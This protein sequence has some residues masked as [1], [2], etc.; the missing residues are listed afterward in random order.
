M[1][2]IYLIGIFLIVLVA[3]KSQTNYYVSL[4][5]DD[6]NTGLSEAQAWRTITF[7]VSAMS[8]VSAG[9]RVNVKAGNYGAENI[10]VDKMGLAS[11]VIV[12]EGYQTTPG[13]SPNL[14]YVFG[15][16]LDASVMPLL[17]GGNRATAGE[18]ITLYSQKYIIFK[19]FQITNYQV[20]VDG[21]NGA[22]NKLENIIAISLGDYDS[23]YDGKGFSFSP[24]GSGEGGDHNTI[25]D[26]VVANAC[27]E[28]ISITGDGNVLDNCKIYCDEDN[29]IHASMDYYIILAGDSNHVKNCYIERVG[30]LEHGGAGIGI[31]E[32]G[33]H[34]LIEN[35]VA[36]DLENGGFYVRWAAVK[37]NEFRNCKAIGTLADV[38][39][40][41][42]R[43]GA[44]F[45]EFNS[46]VVENCSSAIRFSVSGEDQ[47]YCGRNNTFNNCIIKNATSDIEFYS[48]AIPGPADNNLF[49]N[50]VFDKATYLFESSRE[51]HDNQMINCIV[52][53]V[54]NLVLGS[55]T[56]NF[57]Y[58]YSDFNN[59]G[60]AMPAGTGNIASNPQFVD[61]ANGDFHLQ[62]GSPCIDAGTANNA[63]S[64]DY[65]GTSRPQ[66]AG[67]EIGAYEFQIPLA[68]EY[69]SSLQASVKGNQVLLKWVVASEVNN[70]YFQIERSPDASSWTILG[71]VEGNGSENIAR[72]YMVYDSSPISGNS[73]YRLKQVDD[74][75]AY[76]YSQIAS[77]FFENAKL[78]LYPNPITGV[79]FVPKQF[80]NEH[81]RIFSLQGN[82]VKSGVVK[83]NPMN[84]S[85][86]K[87]GVYLFE[88]RGEKFRNVKVARIVKK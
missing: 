84:I 8:P 73:Y 79:V 74:D 40:I 66:G 65:E 3:A 10:Q 39:G 71:R 9:D 12:I 4:S 25:K 82:L 86:L 32:Y 52:K 75:G 14:N 6:N 17:D 57:G 1:K 42:I 53:D 11:Q 27:A 43:D 24:N 2:K 33:E 30:D 70:D 54:D 7:A 34:N 55:E 76:S 47:D 60:F 50:C 49:A 78:D 48:W 61:E 51:N 15:D 85:E 81:Y 88:I 38:N 29:T 64:E 56:L 68:V 44:S 5:G 13:D 69:L 62:A 80:I 37:N 83:T 18:A 87:S 59:N 26:C 35:C 46:C 41:L 72:N 77:V 28:G 21:W 67:F 22:Y 16:P 19:N 20:A 58:T 36:K 31:K 45:N 23:G 63:P